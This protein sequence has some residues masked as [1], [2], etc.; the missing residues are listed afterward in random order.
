MNTIDEKQ[1]AERLL[2]G[3]ENGG[4][5][6]ADAVIIAEN[7]DPVL[8]YVIVSFLRA[9]YPA[10]DPAASSVLER[11]VKLTTGNPAVLQKHKEGAQDPV[12][13]WFESEHPYADF[14]GR[15]REVIELVVEKLET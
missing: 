6:A 9:V 8:I 2:A 7:L 5:S 12:T 13:G 11:V 1:E 3:L 4:L 15:G 14:R 10:S